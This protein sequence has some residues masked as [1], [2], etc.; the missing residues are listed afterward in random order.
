MLIS[1]LIKAIE[2]LHL[3]RFKRK[4]NQTIVQEHIQGIRQVL[5][6]ALE[7][8]TGSKARGVYANNT[9][10]TSLTCNSSWKSIS[11]MKNYSGA[12]KNKARVVRS[13]GSGDKLKAYN[14][15]SVTTKNC[16]QSDNQQNPGSVWCVS[17]PTYSCD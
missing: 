6:P 17:T 2:L 12:S 7:V 1:V 11:W 4:E 3:L 9:T 16:R 5:T 8:Y 14:D 10:Q 13:N 15:C